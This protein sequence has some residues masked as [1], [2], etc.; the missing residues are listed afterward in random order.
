M[1]DI[2]LDSSGDIRV[3]PLGEITVTESISQAIKIHLRWIFQEWR[4]GPE[5]GFPYFEEV[6]IK[7]PN[8]PKIRQL[9][10]S[11]ILS[12]DGVTDAE[13][14]GV[15]FNKAERKA[16]IQYIVEIDGEIYKEEVKLYG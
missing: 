7:N 9:V 10:R 15:D 13:V 5:L 1:I 4:L 8:I 11:E 16:V 12:I 3:S 2:L 14:I 6:L